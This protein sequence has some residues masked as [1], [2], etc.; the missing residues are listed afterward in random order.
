MEESHEHHNG[1]DNACHHGFAVDEVL[2]CA[3]TSISLDIKPLPTPP[4]ALIQYTELLPTSTYIKTKPCLPRFH[5]ISD[6]PPS[7]QGLR[8]PP[9]AI[10]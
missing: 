1:E 6:S 8:A 7:P 9:V 10:G 2:V 3:S 4:V 5:I